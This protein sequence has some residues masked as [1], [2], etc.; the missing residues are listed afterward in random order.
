MKSIKSNRYLFKFIQN[1][2]IE[3]IL[4]LS[5]I[6]FPTFSQNQTILKY[7][8]ILNLTCFTNSKIEGITG[9]SR[10]IISPKVIRAWKSGSLNLTYLKSCELARI[11][12]R[13]YSDGFTINKSYSLNEKR[14]TTVSDVLDVESNAVQEFSKLANRM[15]YSSQCE[16]RFLSTST[17]EMGRLGKV[18]KQALH[19][20]SAS[21][22]LRQNLNF[23]GACP[24]YI[25]MNSEQRRNLWVFVM[26]SMSHFESSCKPT[27]TNQGPNGIASGLLQ[28][29]HDNEDLYPKW[30]PDFNCERGASKS[31]KRS[32]QCALTM[33]N[34][35]IYKEQTFFNDRSHW[36]VLRKSQKPG[37]QAYQ[38]K[39]AISQIPDCKANPLY[40]VV[41][42][43]AADKK[44]RE[45]RHSQGPMREDV[46]LR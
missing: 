34:N 8:S 10:S 36:Q 32:L 29:H 42:L 4:S 33:L 30:D 41:D 19:A 37:S 3:C 11:N 23:G 14:I 7:T 45:V 12:P 26:M 2:K 6:L 15:H 40:F 28:L 16:K 22:L 35:Q 38:I 46:A 18:V 13:A 20:N 44:L 39:Y 31:A 21:D 1:K 9:K 27:A 24:G 43:K 17:N 5:L 25:E